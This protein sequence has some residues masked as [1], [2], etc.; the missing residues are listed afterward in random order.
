MPVFPPIAAN[1][2]CL[3][4][5]FLLRLAIVYRYCRNCRVAAEFRYA[6]ETGCP[7]VVLFADKHVMSVG[8]LLTVPVPGMAYVT[9]EGGADV[10]DVAC[11]Q[12]D[13]QLRP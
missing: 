2:R 13:K 10:I 4:L 11:S 9:G 3:Q 1:F 6:D 12:V 8:H 7:L 5:R